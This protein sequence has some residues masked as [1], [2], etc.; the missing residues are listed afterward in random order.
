M[1]EHL[2]TL[3]EDNFERVLDNPDINQDLPPDTDLNPE[4]DAE[5]NADAFAEL[6]AKEAF[7]EFARRG[8]LNNGTDRSLFAAKEDASAQEARYI[9]R[10]GHTPPPV[11][12]RNPPQHNRPGNPPQHNRPG[13]PPS[14]GNH[15]HPG[16]APRFAPPAYTPHMSPALRAVDP[17]A[18]F[19]C[20]YSHTYI[21]LNNRQ[22]FWFFPTFI[23]RRS[24]A[25]YRW[26]ANRWVFMGFDLRMI[27][28]FFCGGR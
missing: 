25:G 26:M 6:D 12:P 15:H 5:F 7:I 22:Q 9:P 13:N 3:K 11:H 2:M 4:E 21:W 23:G 20:L 27:D 18:I 19:G 16:S 1:R 17:G 10:P 8:S 14:R 24:V 28:S